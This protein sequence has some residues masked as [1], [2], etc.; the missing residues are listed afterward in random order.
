MRVVPLGL[1]ERMVKL[2]LRGNKDHKEKEVKKVCE[3]SVV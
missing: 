3:D 1:Q 2:V